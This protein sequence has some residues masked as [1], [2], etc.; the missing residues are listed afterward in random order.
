LT[1]IE[2]LGALVL[3][4]K[5]EKENTST[6]SGLILTADSRDSELDRGVVIKVGPGE[7][8]Q[9]GITHSIPINVGDIV[10]YANQHATEVLGKNREEYQFI[11]WRNLFGVEND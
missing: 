1:T 10:I 7:R 2:P 3:V 11:N 5:I 9:T 6:A 4:K 8:D